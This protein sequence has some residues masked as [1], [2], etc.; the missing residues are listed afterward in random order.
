MRNGSSGTQEVVS[1]AA[2]NPPS[3]LQLQ[4][5]V[6]CP[7]PMSLV[8]QEGTDSLWTSCKSCLLPTFLP[9]PP[10]ELSAKG[11]AWSVSA[12][13]G[14]NEAMEGMRMDKERGG[15]LLTELNS[16]D[17][18]STSSPDH[19]STVNHPNL[20]KKRVANLDKR[21]IATIGVQLLWLGIWGNGSWVWV[22][23]NV[24]PS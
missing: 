3:A 7:C 24:M 13:K 10:G 2:L 14:E 15:L 19:S 22:Y 11:K 20:D 17:L 9:K 18:P 6:P 5:S 21:L 1:V 8:E 12:E 4:D 16:G 23:I